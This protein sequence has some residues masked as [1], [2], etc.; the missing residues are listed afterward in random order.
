MTAHNWYVT[1]CL[2]LLAIQANEAPARRHYLFQGPASPKGSRRRAINA[3][4]AN[5][6]LASALENAFTEALSEVEFN[7]SYK[8]ILR[9]RRVLTLWVIIIDDVTDGQVKGE[10][11]WNVKVVQEHA[12]RL[13]YVLVRASE[14]LSYHLLTRCIGA[15]SP[16]TRRQK[17][18]LGNNP[19]SRKPLCASK[20]V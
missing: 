16:R 20:D 12:R 10:D 7:T 5:S 14:F 3:A 15:R 6:V 17:S 11:V 9:R 19:Q 2:L 13:L 4:R 18:H 8:T 1:C